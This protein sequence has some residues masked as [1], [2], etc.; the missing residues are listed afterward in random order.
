MTNGTTT[1]PANA[2]RN[3]NYIGRSNWNDAMYA[4]TMAEILFYNRDLT[5]TERNKVESYLA[6]KYGITLDQTTSTNYTLSDG[7]IAWNATTGGTYKNDITGIGRDD[8]TTLNQKKSQSANNTG[9][10]IVEFTGATIFN[11]RALTWANNSTATGT[12]VNTENPPGYKR[13]NREWKFQ[14]TLADI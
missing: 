6:L 8:T 3:N 2:I 1:I 13:I 5:V 14:E 10:I 12:W 7:S 9:D 11:L 4:G